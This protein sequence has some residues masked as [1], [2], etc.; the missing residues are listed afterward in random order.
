MS[1]F[2]T[3]P[4]KKPRDTTVLLLSLLDL[5]LQSTVG[6]RVARVELK[7]AFIGEEATS[8]LWG[9]FPDFLAGHNCGGDVDE[10]LSSWFE[11][12]ALVAHHR[13]LS[14]L[15]NEHLEG[16]LLLV[17]CAQGHR[18]G[19]EVQGELQ[20]VPPSLL[21]FD[22]PLC[23]REG[24]KKNRFFFGTLSQTSDPTHPPRTFGT[25]LGEKWKHFIFL[26]K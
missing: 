23:L 19:V 9:D 2:K 15:A 26:K 25:P 8:S 21:R 16:I 11:I 1:C 20:S 7:V 4:G 5:A 10:V 24:V 14:W 6:E 3:Y 22:F 18:V 12:D 17:Q 13:E